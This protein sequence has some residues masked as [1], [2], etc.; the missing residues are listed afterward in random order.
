[1]IGTD[2]APEAQVKA[3]A[4]QRAA[5][6]GQPVDLLVPLHRHLALATGCLAHGV[7]AVGQVGDR[8]F[9]GFGDRR[10]MLLVVGDQRR[11]GLG[12]EMVGKVEHAGGQGL[13]GIISD[14]RFATLEPNSGAHEPARTLL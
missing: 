1:M 7:E 8:L 5:A 6:S 12:R 4:A 10:E 11:V 14:L 9:E 2:D 13:H 3:V